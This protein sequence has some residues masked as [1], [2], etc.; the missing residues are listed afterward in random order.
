MLKGGRYMRLD[1]EEVEDLL[2]R[3]HKHAHDFRNGY[4]MCIGEVAGDIDN[5]VEL[6]GNLTRQ[7]LDLKEASAFYW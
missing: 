6:V 2:R 1:E 5:V 7:T 3:L 4:S